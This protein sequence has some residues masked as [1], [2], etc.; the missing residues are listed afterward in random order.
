MIILDT[1]V[2]SEVM[3]ETPDERVSRWVTRQKTLHLAITA[4]TVAEIQRGL[5]R[6]P[7]GKRRK[8]LEASFESFID[9]GFEGRV[10]PFDQDAAFLYGHVCALRERKRLAAD[11]VDLMIAA[12]AR[13]ADA[14]LAT[15][16]VADFEHCGIRLLN[17]WDTRP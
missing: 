6:L 2:V 13:N 14:T 9:R 12:I 16:N 17:P 15:R 3:R 11:P 1:N 7:A 8:R 4:I 10:L 5:M